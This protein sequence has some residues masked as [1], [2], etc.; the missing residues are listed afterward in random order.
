MPPGI[1]I[2][3]WGFP[4]TTPGHETV[5]GAVALGARVIEKHFTDDTGRAGPD[6]AFSMTPQTWK[7]MVERAGNLFLSLGDG[8]KRIEPNEQELPVSSAV[9]CITGITSRQVKYFRKKI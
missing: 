9:P 2:S 3:S 7:E 1:R 5:L 6:H 8:V 4:T